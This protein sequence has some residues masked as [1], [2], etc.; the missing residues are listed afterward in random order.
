MPSKIA[1]LAGLFMV[2]VE[3]LFQKSAFVKRRNYK[4]LRVPLAQLCLIIL[5]LLLAANVEGDYAIYGQR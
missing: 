2:A 1:L 4:H 3:F 5:I